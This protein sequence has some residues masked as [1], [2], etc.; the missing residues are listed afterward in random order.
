LRHGFLEDNT[1]ERRT[2][3]NFPE[4]HPPRVR[5]HRHERVQ[6]GARSCAEVCKHHLDA[7][8]EL[9]NPF[10]AGHQKT[11]SAPQN[12]GVNT[13]IGLDGGTFVQDEGQN[14]P[15]I[16]IQD[17]A[18]KISPIMGLSGPSSPMHLVSTP[19]G[20]VRVKRQDK[21]VSIVASSIKGG[22]SIPSLGTIFESQL[23][24]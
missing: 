21:K 5:E 14:D 11:T 6:H 19:H 7:N 23:R 22:E 9:I 8:A 15:F 16:G 20:H 13:C 10:S 24:H 4:P 1:W 17:V 12:R 18:V 2:P 3:H